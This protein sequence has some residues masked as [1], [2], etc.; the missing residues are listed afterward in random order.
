M[1]TGSAISLDTIIMII[2][3]FIFDILLYVNASALSDLLPNVSFMISP[4]NR[5]SIL[6]HHRRPI[7]TH[8]S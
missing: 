1:E 6:T 7:L 2:I 3:L 4:V 5:L 8:P